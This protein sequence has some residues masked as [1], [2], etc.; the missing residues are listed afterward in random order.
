MGS[1][2]STPCFTG[3]AGGNATLR[4]LLISQSC[5]EAVSSK[6]DTRVFATL[7]LH[8]TAIL[9]PDVLTDWT[10]DATKV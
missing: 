10:I 8:H 1:I 6:Q 4:D 2:G 7:P 5:Q 3:S 9:Y